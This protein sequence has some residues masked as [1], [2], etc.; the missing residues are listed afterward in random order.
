MIKLESYSCKQ[1]LKYPDFTL[2]LTLKVNILWLVCSFKDKPLRT[3]K[4]NATAQSAVK[5]HQ[6]FIFFIITSSQIVQSSSVYEDEMKPLVLAFNRGI[7]FDSMWTNDI[8]S[9]KS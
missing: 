3:E 6:I 1:L 5:N 4:I 9:S 7:T 8:V 2:T